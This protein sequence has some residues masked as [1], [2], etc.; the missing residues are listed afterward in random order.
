MRERRQT[1]TPA[2]M[3]ALRQRTEIAKQLR[4]DNVDMGELLDDLETTRVALRRWLRAA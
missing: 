3:A 2:E 4:V 1:P